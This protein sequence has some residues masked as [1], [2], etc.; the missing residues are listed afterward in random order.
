M[1]ATIFKEKMIITSSTCILSLFNLAFVM[2]TQMINK[3]GLVIQSAT[4]QEGK[5]CPVINHEVKK[6]KLLIFGSGGYVVL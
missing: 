6:I 1:H 3:G 2:K 4:R 5:P